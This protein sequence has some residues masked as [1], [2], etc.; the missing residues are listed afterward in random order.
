MNKPE[1][2]INNSA[3]FDVTICCRSLC[4]DVLQETST[5]TDKE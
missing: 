5:E 1:K 2:K 4:D 3:V